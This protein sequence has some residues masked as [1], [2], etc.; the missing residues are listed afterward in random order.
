[1]ACTSTMTQ[2]VLYNLVYQQWWPVGD[3]HDAGEA[4]PHR[5]VNTMVK[6]LEGSCLDNKLMRDEQA[7]EEDILSNTNENWLKF[8]RFEKMA[9]PFVRSLVEGEDGDD[10]LPKVSDKVWVASLRGFGEAISSRL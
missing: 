6:A 2:R 3:G 10:G 5:A 1:M 4:S 9:C 7:D 8:E